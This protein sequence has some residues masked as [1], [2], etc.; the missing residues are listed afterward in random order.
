MSLHPQGEHRQPTCDWSGDYP[1][2]EC[3]ATNEFTNSAGNDCSWEQTTFEN[4]C[5]DLTPAP[6]DCSRMRDGTPCD[7]GDI[8]TENDACSSQVCA[9]TA[10]G[11]PPPPP[12]AAVCEDDA[13]WTS[14]DGFDCSGHRPTPTQ[15]GTGGWDTYCDDGAT[16]TACPLSCGV[17]SVRRSAFRG[18]SAKPS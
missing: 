2:E 6:T 15:D 3:C 7:D 1:F 14:A 9:G 10:L 4:C 16:Q 18:L 13:S 5:T 11:S 17:C 12:P 8:G